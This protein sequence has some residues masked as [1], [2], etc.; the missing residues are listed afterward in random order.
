MMR[1]LPLL[2]VVLSLTVLQKTWQVFSVQAVQAE[3]QAPEPAETAIA[4]DNTTAT[5][6]VMGDVPEKVG[7]LE[8]KEIIDFT[9]SELDLLQSLRERREEIR[10]R[11]EQLQ[12]QQRVLE[13]MQKRLEDKAEELNNIKTKVEDVRTEITLLSEKFKKNES[14]QIES[15]TRIYEKMKSK[16]AARIFDNLDTEIVID[17]VKSMKEARVAP[18]IAA[19]DPKKA[20]IITEKL[21][22]R[23]E[24]P[25]I[26]ESEEAVAEPVEDQPEPT[27]AL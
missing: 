12:Q 21:G 24:L 27:P 16:D 5:E 20:T 23:T 26:G 7:K 22:E 17:V 9:P 15:L 2:I 18:I 6:A 11:E 14:S 13:A 19:M 1:L 4:E 3:K 10:Q 25:D 8:G